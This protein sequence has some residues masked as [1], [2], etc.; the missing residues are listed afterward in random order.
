MKKVSVVSV[1]VLWGLL[2]FMFVST[3]VFSA[4][5]PLANQLGVEKQQFAPGSFE[6][7]SACI[8][9]HFDIYE[10]WSKS[11]HAYAWSNKWY[12]D[13]YQMAHVDPDAVFYRLLFKDSDGNL[14]GKSWRAVDIGYDRRI[15]AQGRDS[16]I[17][18]IKLP[19]TGSFR[20]DVRLM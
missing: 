16:E 9:C 2:L 17:Y 3:P 5:D 1:C 12:Q 14:T 10:Q 4:A 6:N 20:A 13:D 8:A 7:P 15:P 18:S 11:M 19:A